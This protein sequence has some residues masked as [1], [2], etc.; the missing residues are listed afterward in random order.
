[1]TLS[2][3]VNSMTKA[4]RKEYEKAVGA[5]PPV[6]ACGAMFENAPRERLYFG[7]FVVPEMPPATE[8]PSHR[9]RMDEFLNRPECAWSARLRPNRATSLERPIPSQA[10]RARRATARSSAPCAS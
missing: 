9:L 5:G 7:N 1:V 10:T 6:L 2:F 4:M 8:L 3:Q